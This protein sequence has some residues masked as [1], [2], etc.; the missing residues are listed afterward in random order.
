[1]TLGK[2]EAKILAEI[3]DVIQTILQYERQ[4]RTAL[5]RE[6]RQ[7]EQDR[8]ARALGTL[9][10]ATM[11]T[12]EETMELLS[13]VRLGHPPAADRRPAG[14]HASTSC[15][16]RRRRPTSR[17]SSATRSTARSA[18][19]PGPSTSRLGCASSAHTGSRKFQV[20]S[21]RFQVE[22][23]PRSFPA[24]TWNLELGTWNL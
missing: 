7:A 8:V 9:G 3:K 22:D 15:S 1:V 16:S 6:R 14:H 13:V 11:I 5:L 24:R 18:T 4:A 23:E 2:S 19:P 17:N 10:S 20:P 21:P 12:A